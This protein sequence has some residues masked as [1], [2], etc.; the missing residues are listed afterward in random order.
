MQS[1]KKRTSDKKG[2]QQRP[3]EVE[4]LMLNRIFSI[5]T[6]EIAAAM[7]VYQSWCKSRNLTPFKVNSLPEVEI[8]LYT[9]FH[10]SSPPNKKQLKCLVEFYN[11]FYEVKMKAINLGPPKLEMNDNNNCETGLAKEIRPKSE[12]I[13]NKTS[14]RVSI[15]GAKKKKKCSD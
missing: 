10:S 2:T 8:Q 12:K 11:K 4:D 13:I 3:W 15:R 1:D 14:R 6:E 9:C 7:E 5:F